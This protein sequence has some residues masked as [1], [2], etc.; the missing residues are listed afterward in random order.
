MNDLSTIK[1]MR[2]VVS[3]DT[4][5]ARVYT[6]DVIV[7]SKFIMVHINHLKEVFCILIKRILKT[8]LSKCIF[9]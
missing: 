6:D 8:N 4:F 5:F 7:F 1:R 2:E 9:A 3:L